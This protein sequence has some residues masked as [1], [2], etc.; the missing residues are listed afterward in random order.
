MEF[1]NDDHRTK[2]NE[3]KL[4]TELLEY[5]E[6]KQE[7]NVIFLNA[8]IHKVETVGITEEK[9]WG[10]EVLKIRSEFQREQYFSK[11]STDNVVSWLLAYR[12][13]LQNEI[14][15]IAIKEGID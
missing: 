5:C 4:I 7:Q 11:L 15:D 3:L 2:W 9:T 10:Y 6:T 8:A 12:S 14:A 1:L 13:T